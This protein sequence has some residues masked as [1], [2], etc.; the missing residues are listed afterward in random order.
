MLEVVEEDNWNHHRLADVVVGVVVVAV[1]VLADM[2]V[3]YGNLVEQ[4]V[5][6]VLVLQHD[7][8]QDSCQVEDFRA[9]ENYYQQRA[10][11]ELLVLD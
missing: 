7:D 11:L 3:G 4:R 9:I 5:H 10:Q 8:H 1:V 2:A 6:F